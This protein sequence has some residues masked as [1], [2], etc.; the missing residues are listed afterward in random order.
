[1]RRC[2][3]SP[4]DG[5][6]TD[7]FLERLADRTRPTK[8]AVSSPSPEFPASETIGRYAETLSDLPAAERDRRLATLE[9]FARYVDRTPDRMVEEIYNRETRKYRKR[10]FYSD[11]AKAF[12]AEQ[13]GP[14]HPT[15]RRATSSLLL[16]RKWLPAPAGAA[17]LDVS[18]PR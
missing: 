1:M 8:P 4:S 17:E 10:G 12:A 16:H 6:P 3:A 14:E 7:G 18:Q 9:A 15:S 5:A 13:D 2:S 11:N